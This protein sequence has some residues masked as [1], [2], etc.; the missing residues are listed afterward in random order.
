MLTINQNYVSNLHIIHKV[1]IVYA[2]SVLCANSSFNCKVK[3]LSLCEQNCLWYISTPNLRTLHGKRKITTITSQVCMEKR[4]KKER[5]WDTKD[6]VPLT[7][8]SIG[9]ELVKNKRKLQSTYLSVQHYGYN[10]VFELRV[11]FF[12]KINGFLVWCMVPMRHIQTCNI[13]SSFCEFPYHFTWACRRANCTYYLSFSST[14]CKCLCL[15]QMVIIIRLKFISCVNP[16]K[17]GN[18]TSRLQI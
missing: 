15:A 3:L 12:N 8:S 16:L 2:N 4:K 11:V 5:G 10:L 7:T 14:T 6:P 18:N 17:Q 9:Y 1:I 13:H